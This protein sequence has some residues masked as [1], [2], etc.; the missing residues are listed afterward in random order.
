MPLSAESAAHTSTDLGLLNLLHLLN[1]SWTAEPAARSSADL[2]ES[3][4]PFRPI[5]KEAAADRMQFTAEKHKCNM[6][7]HMKEVIHLHSPFT[8][9]KGCVTKLEKFVSH[10]SSCFRRCTGSAQGVVLSISGSRAS[11]ICMS[12]FAP[13]SQVDGDA[14]RRQASC[15]AS[16]ILANATPFAFTSSTGLRGSQVSAGSWKVVHTTK[17]CGED[18]KRK[19]TR[20]NVRP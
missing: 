9:S 19:G 13:S 11:W 15:L 2:F 20:C 12:I 6:L 18:V 5:L 8:H 14:R 7:C 4:G 1:W 16:H 17:P 10:C 3:S